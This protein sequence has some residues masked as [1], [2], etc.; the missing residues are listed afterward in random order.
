M[1][2]LTPNYG[3][4]VGLLIAVGVLAV[5][6]TG[7]VARAVKSEVGRAMLTRFLPRRVIDDAH[8]D[9]MS[10]VTQPRSV[11]A[12]VLVTDL[13]GFTA[14]SEHLSPA[15]VLE[16]LNEVQGAL[17][18]VVR[19]YGGTVDKFMGDGMLAVFGVPE[20]LD[21][22]A[23]RSVCAANEMLRVIDGINRTRDDALPVRIGI[24]VHSG[25]VV[26]GC[27][28][29]GLRLEFTII[30]D[31]VNTASRLEALTKEKGVTTL[32]SNDTI[33][34]ADTA[35]SATGSLKS[36]AVQEALERARD[37]EAK[38]RLDER[39]DGDDSD[40]DDTVRVRTTLLE[41]PRVEQLGEVAIRGRVKPMRVHTL[42][43]PPPSQ[44]R[45]LSRM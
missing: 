29:S 26:A 9:P 37:A 38:M 43:S 45:L 2:E 22:H 14:F 33:T 4:M 36:S 1:A 24:G 12:T 28:G 20:E 11:D 18:R 41:L 6:M 25:P 8:T 5:W 30:G 15:E 17:A 10:L 7:I 44:T 13:R 42:S 32:I 40:E 39:D 34:L 16:F 31:T 3:I 21:D 23:V 19:T 35:F 27:L